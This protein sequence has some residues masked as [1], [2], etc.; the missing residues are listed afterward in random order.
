MKGALRMLRYLVAAGVVLSALGLAATPAL[1]AEGGSKLHVIAFEPDQRIW[2]IAL[3]DRYLTWESEQGE[4]GTPGLVQRDLRT[5]RQ[6]TLAARVHPEY[7]LASTRGWVA[8][9]SGLHSLF[10]VRHDGSGRRTLTADLAA[11]FAG[12]G[13][14]IAWAELDDDTYRVVVRNMGTGKQWVAARIPR[15]VSTRCYR[16]DGMALA[17]DG[18]VFTRGAIGPQP[19]F[20]VRRGYADPAP[21]SVAVPHDPQPELAPSSAGALYYAFGRG[22]LRWDFGSRKP[23][24]T[25]FG[26]ADQNTILR[27][28]DGHWFT[29]LTRGCR[30]TLKVTRPGHA[31]ATLAASRRILTLAHLKPSGCADIVAFHADGNRAISAWRFQQ[32]ATDKYPVGLNLAGIV[33]S[34][35]F[36]G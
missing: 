32:P 27:F 5:K 30:E 17:D 24:A 12:R 18:V 8:Y 2:N 11:P 9:A 20:I 13:E 10:A 25:R 35:R 34:Q 28:E 16:I 33:F 19:S 23:R 22:W 15:C 7:G 4:E 21:T 29:R 1:S 3:T 26:A 31:G 6:R 36:R 14:R